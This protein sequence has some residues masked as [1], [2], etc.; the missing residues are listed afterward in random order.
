MMAVP[1]FEYDQSQVVRFLDAGWWSHDGQW[2]LKTKDR[3][4]PEVAME[5]NE[6]AARA[7]GK[8]E[9][10]R[11]RKLLG[12]SDVNDC[13]GFAR[14]LATLW[15]IREAPDQLVYR[16]VSPDRLEVGRRYCRIFEM[17]QA[18]GMEGMG[19]GGLPG[20]RGFRAR[21]SGWSEV[22]S[23]E[24]EFLVAEERTGDPVEQIVCEHTIVRRRKR[25]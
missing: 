19:I 9:M 2:F 4:G 7:L 13:E 21:L 3:F 16:H 25:S 1:P 23:R 14:L 6:A 22:L 15:A 24:Y 17:A 20:C 8:I 5:L 10:R 11:L 12:L 18:A